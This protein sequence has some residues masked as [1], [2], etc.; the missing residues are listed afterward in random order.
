MMAC[1]GDR[2]TPVAVFFG[3]EGFTGL[4]AGH[5]TFRLSPIAISRAAYLLLRIPVLLASRAAMNSSSF[6][7]RPFA[8]RIS[9]CLVMP[10]IVVC[11]AAE[12]RGTESQE[13]AATVTPEGA[14]IPFGDT[15]SNGTD[16]QINALIAFGGNVYAGGSFAHVGSVAANHIARWDGNAWSSLGSDAQNGVDDIVYALATDGSNLY[17]GGQFQNAGGASARCIAK[18][19]GAAWSALGT[20]VGAPA[21]NSAVNGLAIF[22]DALYAVGMFNQAGGVFPLKNVAA[23]DLGASTWGDVGGGV[24]TTAKSVIAFQGV[25]Y[26][27][28]QFTSAG[29]GGS[30]ST[31]FI[32]GWNGANWSAV[33]GGTDG[34]VDAMAGIGSSLYAGGGFAHANGTSTLVHH[35]ARFNG[36]WS[37]MG[38]G[39]STDSGNTVRA[40]AAVGSVLYVGGTFT[41]ANGIA[42]TNTAQWD[43]STWASV[44][45]GAENGVDGTVFALSPFAGDVM[46]GGAFAHAGTQS[47]ANIAA[48]RSDIIFSDGFDG[49][50]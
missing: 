43:G 24:N 44:G 36:A 29:P 8:R 11:L 50:P 31:K 38:T 9:R 49:L 21:S 10:L 1:N 7:C 45:S 16:G 13:S 18:W 42:T 30:V 26:V 3:A 15:T 46:V 28:G 48:W 20:G 14:W 25:V 5:A 37:A 22:N 33:S 34:E 19:D 35:I 32:A 2:L 23:Y 12:V 6:D 41:S 27:G 47:S 17:V 4:T 40:L 39:M